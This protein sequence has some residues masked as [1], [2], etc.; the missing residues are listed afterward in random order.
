LCAQFTA[1]GCI[2]FLLGS[3]IRIVDDERGKKVDGIKIPHS[4]SEVEETLS[5]LN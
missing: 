1:A 4:V 3:G 2:V 5:L